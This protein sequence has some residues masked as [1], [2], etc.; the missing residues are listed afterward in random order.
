MMK[1]ASWVTQMVKDPPAV[2]ETWHRSWVGKI[3]W[4]RERLPT[5]VFWPGEFHGLY[6]SWG[7]PLWLS[8]LRI[9]LQCR[10]PGFNP[11]VGKM[12]WRR[13]RLPTPVF[14]PREFHGLY[15][16]T[17]LSNFHTFTL[18][19]KRQ[20][21]ETVSF[22]LYLQGLEQG[23]AYWCYTNTCQMHRLPL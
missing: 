22:L 16:R 4:R 1:W 12:P 18:P 5:S 14:W 10:R 11:W 3:P 9:C 15:S 21:H 17:R 7:L 13:E 8:W 6:S 20:L 23:L 19:L 2:Q